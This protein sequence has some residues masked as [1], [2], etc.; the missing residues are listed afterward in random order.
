MQGI[1]DAELAD[2]SSYLL[3]RDGKGGWT[4][5]RSWKVR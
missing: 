1:I 3:E 4:I 5:V 2:G